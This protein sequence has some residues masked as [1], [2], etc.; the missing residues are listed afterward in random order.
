MRLRLLPPLLRTDI[1]TL[2]VKEKLA[3][4]RKILYLFKIEITEHCPVPD[5]ITV[6]IVAIMSPR[7]VSCGLE[8]T[9]VPDLQAALQFSSEAG[10]DFVTVPIVNPRYLPSTSILSSSVS[11]ISIVKCEGVRESSRLRRSPAVARGRSPGPTSSFPAATGGAWWWAGPASPLMLTA[12]SST[13]GT[14]P[15]PDWCRN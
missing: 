11:L 2:P 6:K 4:L 13:S 9:H 3:V 8:L 5:Q 1:V 7:R 14:T 10:Y 12:R 15:R